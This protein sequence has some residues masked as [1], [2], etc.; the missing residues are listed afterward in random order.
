[1]DVEAQ[2][3]DVGALCLQR[4]GCQ[5]G[6]VGSLASLEPGLAAG[7]GEQCVDQLL[8]VLFGCEYALVRFTQ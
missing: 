8:E 1:V 5:D 3:L 4:S 6:E 2:A 7:K